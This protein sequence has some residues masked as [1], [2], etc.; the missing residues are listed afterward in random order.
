[1][2]YINIVEPKSYNLKFFKMDLQLNTWLADGEMFS[3]IQGD[4]MLNR[5]CHKA[6]QLY[7]VIVWFNDKQY[8]KSSLWMFF[9]CQN[10]IHI[11]FKDTFS[12]KKIEKLWLTMMHCCCLSSGFS[13]RLL[14][15]V[16]SIFHCVVGFHVQHNYSSSH[17]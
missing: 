3:K 17:R 6:F 9:Q 15:E 1:M 7:C 11:C 12:S 2:H 13:P 8:V 14:T 4:E 16:L 10:E 5:R